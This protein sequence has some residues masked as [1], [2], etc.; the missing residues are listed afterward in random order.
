MLL[1]LCLVLAA[2]QQETTRVKVVDGR[3]EG[4]FYGFSAVSDLWG[5]MRRDMRTIRKD[6]V[7]YWGAPEGSFEE[8]TQR[9][10]TADE[11]KES[12]NYSIDGTKFNFTYRDGSK[13]EGEIT[14]ADDGCITYIR[15]SA[16]WFYPIRRGISFDL[17]GYFS[18]STSFNNNAYKMS[19][20]TYTSYS[21]HKNGLFVLES[22]ASTTCR[23]DVT[24]EEMRGEMT[25][26][27]GGEAKDR[28]GRFEVKGSGISL[29]FENGTKQ[30]M[31]IGQI[32]DGKNGA[33][34]LLLLGRSLYDGIPGKL[35]SDDLPR[36][37]AE[38]FELRLPKGWSTSDQEASGY[39]VHTISP[40]EGTGFA[41]LAIGMDV[42]SSAKAGGAETVTELRKLV[43]GWVGAK[44]ESAGDVEAMSLDGTDARRIPMQ[45][46]REGTTIRVDAIYAVKTGRAMLLVALGTVEGAKAR[47]EEIKRILATARFTVDE[48]VKTETDDV[49]FRLAKAWK[50]NK[51]EQE[52][53]ATL[54]LLPP[55]VKEGEFFGAI[56]SQASAFKAA[57]EKKAIAWVR[58]QVEEA[59]PGVQSQG[60]PEI[61]TVDGAP[62][63]A[64]RYGAKTESGDVII[65]LAHAV[66]K[67]GKV[68]MMIAG[69]KEAAVSKHSGAARRAFETVRVKK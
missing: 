21:F 61:F 22:G 34:V 28:I 9:A 39:R 53:A 4:V 67:N 11:K 50:T 43:A 13:E 63:V 20:M 15:M 41:I 24:F 27:F 36:C 54:A 16:M 49:E 35:P 26:H 65:V 33:S 18:C 25:T 12:G 2:P 64:L 56:V 40:G 17:S 47:A 19:T 38:Q 51:V 6:G 7:M 46:D 52:G 30:S 14:F 62:S 5:N 42:D 10:L 57:D 58:Q 31:F 48:T 69:G 45:F 55:G 3:I 1:A 59:I 29:V 68:V 44:L 32:G 66:I 8:F 23:S 37:K 60:E